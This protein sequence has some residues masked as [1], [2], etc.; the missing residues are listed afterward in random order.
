M[1]RRTSFLTSTAAVGVLAAAGLRGTMRRFVVA[2]QS[3]SPALNDGDW[4]IA[5]RSTA[6]PR[7]GE[8]IVFE[9]PVRPEFS[10]VKRIVGLPNETVTIAGGSVLIDAETLVEPWCVEPTR[11][12]GEWGLSDHEIFVLSDA[13][14]STIAD[15][16]AFGP[17]HELAGQWKVRVR[18]W[19]PRSAG[20][21]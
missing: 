3:M 15:S 18:Y 8:V 2:E 20:R 9:H 17:I 19:P 5:H 10:L 16:R 4:I 13:R 12:D 21:I 1:K 7:R 6:P 11:P 14:T